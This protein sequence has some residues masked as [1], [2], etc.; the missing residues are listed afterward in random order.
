M[1][2]R[3]QDILDLCAEVRERRAAEKK[4]GNQTENT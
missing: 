3:A 4:A 2:I 1:D